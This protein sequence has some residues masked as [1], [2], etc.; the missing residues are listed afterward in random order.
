[1]NRKRGAIMTDHI[2]LVIKMSYEEYKKNIKQQSELCGGLSD[3][4]RY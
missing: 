4:L 2:E 3:L 1:M